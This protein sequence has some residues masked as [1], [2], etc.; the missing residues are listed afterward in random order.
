MPHIHLGMASPIPYSY[1]SGGRTNWQVADIL[2]A[3]YGVI[4]H[5]AEMRRPVIVDAVT[6]QMQRAFTGL[7]SGKPPN[8]DVLR[9][10]MDAIQRDFRKFIMTRQLDGQVRGVPTAAALHGVN[11]RLKHPYAKRGAR[12]SFIDTGLYIGGFK[13]WFDDA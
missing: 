1:G 13:A 8:K 9:P 10:A 12:P 5:F 6:G 2:E 3:K 7:V 11:H 4:G